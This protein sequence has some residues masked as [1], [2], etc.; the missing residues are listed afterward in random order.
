MSAGLGGVP[1]SEFVLLHAAPIEGHG[2]EDL[3]VRSIGVGKTAAAFG[4]LDRLESKQF[5]SN[6]IGRFVG[7]SFQQRIGTGLAP[8]ALGRALQVRGAAGGRSVAEFG[9]VAHARRCPA[10]RGRGLELTC[11]GAAVSGLGPPVI[12][13]LAGLDGSVPA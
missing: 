11:W 13:L 10:L 12:T 3:G 4:G 5:T 6:P 8:P 1:H 9:D 7:Q 2:L